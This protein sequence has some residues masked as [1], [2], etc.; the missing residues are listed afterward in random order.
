MPCWS[1][2]WAFLLAGQGIRPFADPSCITRS[3]H[4]NAQRR[5]VS[6][7]RSGLP[8][9]GY[10]AALFTTSGLSL[11]PSTR[12]HVKHRQHG[13]ALG[14][15]EDPKP[16]GGVF[17]EKP[18]ND[19]RS[20]GSNRATLWTARAPPVSGQARLGGARHGPC[21]ACIHRPSLNTHYPQ[22]RW[23]RGRPVVNLG[24]T[25]PETRYP[26]KEAISGP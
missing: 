14:A 23:V 24:E 19:L 1:I 16:C 21:L 6:R 11:S 8:F 13:R 12:F 17:L 15:Q 9:S 3:P 10:C 2:C 25:P 26:R 20:C 4:E 7:G 22:N 5:P 18:H